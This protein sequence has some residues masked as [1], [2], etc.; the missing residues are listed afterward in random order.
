M[1]AWGRLPLRMSRLDGTLRLMAAIG[2]AWTATGVVSCGLW[3]G[4]G[5]SG[6]VD[7]DVWRCWDAELKKFSRQAPCFTAQQLV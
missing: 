7:D 1:T 3:A 5:D 2:M 6:D 4:V